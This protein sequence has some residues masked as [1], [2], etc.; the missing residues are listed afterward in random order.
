M[1]EKMALCDDTVMAI[2]G[3]VTKPIQGKYKNE[4]YTVN[5]WITYYILIRYTLVHLPFKYDAEHMLIMV[6]SYYM[7]V[8]LVINVTMLLFYEYDNTCVL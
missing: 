7:C 1:F 3:A 6:I 2:Y 8:T 4:I 5:K